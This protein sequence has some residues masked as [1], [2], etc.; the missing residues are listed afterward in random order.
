VSADYTRFKARY[1]DALAAF[2]AEADEDARERA[3]ALGREAVA[4]GIGVLDIAAIHAAAVERN[5]PNAWKFFSEVLAPFEMAL[6]GFREANATL[7]RSAEILEQRVRDEL[8][9]AQRNAEALRKTEE[10]LRQSQKMDAIGRLAGGVAHDFNNLLSVILSYSETL[11][12]D[13]PE[14]DP[15]RDDVEEIRKAGYRASELTR[16]LLLFSRRQVSEAKLLDLNEVVAGT[17]KMLR[18]LVGADIDFHTIQTPALGQVRADPGGIEQVILNLVVNARDAMPTGGKLTVETCNVVLDEEYARQHVGARA[19][20]HVMLAVSDTGSGMDTATQSRI[21]E[22]F[23]T[24]KPKGKGTGLGLSTVFGIVQQHHGSIWVYSERDRGTTFKVY[25]PQV[26]KAAQPAAVLPVAR[27]LQRGHET[28]LLVDDDEQVRTAAAAILRKHH[29]NVIE[30]QS[31]GEAVL[32][33]EKHPGEIHLLLSDVVMPQLSGPELAQR[34]S[35]LRPG[36]RVLCMSGYTDDSI[37]RHGLLDSTI[38]YLQKPLTPQLLTAKV[39]E[40]LDQ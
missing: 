13:I 20:P 27:P 17:D 1:G 22:P 36:I 11:L 35:G 32:H 5:G 29:Y 33:A 28:I 14:N 30:A 31:A 40:V 15:M 24:T 7:Q 34:V 10:Q 9:Q 18:R 39:R 8:A 21:F 26:E 19:G 2:D 4:S 23:F 3:Y 6:R 12:E 38:T 16:Q 25:I 37:V